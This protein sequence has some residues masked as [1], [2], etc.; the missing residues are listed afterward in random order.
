MGTKSL[1][2]R[3]A[4]QITEQDGH[5]LFSGRWQQKLGRRSCKAPRLVYVLMTGESPEG[6]CVRRTCG[7]K[8]CVAPDHMTVLTRSA[9]SASVPS[10]WKA[11]TTCRYGHDLSTA[12]I[13][14]ERNQ[15]GSK[16][17]CRECGDQRRAA[18]R[19]R[20]SADAGA[21]A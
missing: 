18:M 16:R 6:L 7:E 1:P 17:Q 10:Y 2:S 3:I 14:P 12:Y 21:T 8:R 5:W 20:Q 4:D 15:G 13:T 19:E 11:Q 9:C